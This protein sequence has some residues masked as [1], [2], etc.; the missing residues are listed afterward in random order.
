MSDEKTE[1]ATDH[2][3]REAREQGNV[4]KSPDLTVTIMLFGIA[5]TLQWAVQ[6]A[7][8]FLYGFFVETYEQLQYYT[9]YD[10]EGID[11]ILLKAALILV[12]CSAPLALVA[13]FLTWLGNLLQVGV[14][15]TAKPLNAAEGFKKLNPIKGFKNIFSMKKVIDLGKAIIKIFIIAWLAYSVV[16]GSLGKILLTTDMAVPAGMALLGNLALTIIQKIAMTMIAVSIL[17]YFLQKWQYEKSLKM[18]KQEIKDEYKKLEGD[19]HV[20]AR[21]RH[22]QMEMA[23]NAG[24]G[25]VADADVVIT[26]PTHYAVALEYKPK[27]GQKAPVVLAKGK[28]AY[29]LEIRR[30]AEENFILIVEDPPTAR[31]LYAQAE[32]DQ[33]I[34]QE[35]F[36]A[37]AKIIAMLYKG[38]RKSKA[39]PQ[40]MLTEIPSV[41]MS[42]ELQIQLENPVD[43]S[44]SPQEKSHPEA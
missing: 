17:D 28:N 43:T 21:I 7:F 16:S 30:I 5:Y 34:P 35:L 29:A 37:V 27:K 8:H 10:L 41:P 20:K 38:R 13:V 18:S 36:Q 42:T 14:N 24:R 11:G 6:N 2:K 44:S 39:A 19:P 40:Q 33:P 3:R 15:I 22:K 4:L 1:P 23:M 9:H 12:I 25:S 31:L 26:N 32:V